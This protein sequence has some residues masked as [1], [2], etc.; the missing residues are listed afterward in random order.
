MKINPEFIPHL[1]SDN[2]NLIMVHI[3]K[4]RNNEY[5]YSWSSNAKGWYRGD[6]INEVTNKCYNN[7]KT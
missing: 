6:K 3:N 7:P 4:M 1:E 2:Y 5:Y